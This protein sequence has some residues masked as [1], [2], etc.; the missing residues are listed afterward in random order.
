MKT[1]VL[2]LIALR[3]YTGCNTS[4]VFFIQNEEMQKM[5]IDSLYYLNEQTDAFE[6]G[7]ILGE[8]FIEVEFDEVLLNNT[9]ENIQL[10]GRIH[11]KVT[12]ERIPFCNIYL[13]STSNRGSL[14]IGETIGNVN[15]EGAFSIKINKSKLGDEKL[16]FH[17]F[18]FIPE[19]FNLSELSGV[20]PPSQK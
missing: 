1:L 11:T 15:Q 8:E 17:C 19:V 3:L 7:A 2:N 13:T 5:R 18:S 12:R 14:L 4:Q 16:V 6:I 9:S 20:L 10:S